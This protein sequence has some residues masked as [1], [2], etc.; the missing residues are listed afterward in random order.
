MKLMNYVCE[1]LDKDFM[2]G[3]SVEIWSNNIGAIKTWF[4]LRTKQMV[5]MYILDMVL[6]IHSILM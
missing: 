5:E 4:V 2:L 6:Y 3:I 1:L